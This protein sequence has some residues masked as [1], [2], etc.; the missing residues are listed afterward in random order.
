M[1]IILTLSITTFLS[2]PYAFA[3]L[4][5]EIST[6]MN[7]KGLLNSTVNGKIISDENG[8]DC[9]VI[10]NPYGS[11]EDD[12]IQISS[13]AYFNSMAYLKEAKKETSFDGTIVYMTKENG[14]RPGGSACGSTMPVSGYKKTVEIK[15]NKLTIRE[16]FRCLL[17]KHE[18][19]QACTIS[20]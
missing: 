16:S 18:V 17:S 15:K 14:K 2:L 12:S 13:R 7:K 20:K 5:S 8:S 6:L 11:E 4:P 9:E 10:S 3:T 19:I 1:K